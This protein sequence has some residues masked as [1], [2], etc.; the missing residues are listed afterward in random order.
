MKAL[1]IPFSASSLSIKRCLRVA[2]AWQA[3]GHQAIF[4]AG[5]EA[6]PALQ[7]AG[8]TPH[9]LPEVTRAQ[10]ER[11]L[12]ILW[13][14]PAYFQRNLR[15]EQ[16]LIAEL[17][18]DVVVSDYRLTSPAAARLAGLP[19]VSLQHTSAVLLGNRPDQ[20][21]RYLVFG[22][23][24]T[25]AERP[26]W[27]RRLLASL[28]QGLFSLPMLPLRYFL[29]RLGFRPAFSPLGL[30]SGDRVLV[31]DL[32]SLL[33]GELPPNCYVVGPLTLQLREPM[34]AEHSAPGE[35]PTITLVYSASLRPLW[36]QL[37]Q[38]LQGLAGQV[39]VTCSESPPP[40]SLRQP[41][42]AVQLPA[43]EIAPESRLVIHAGEPAVLLQ[44]LAWGAPSLLLPGSPEQMLTAVQVQ[45][46]HLGRSLWQPGQL[47]LPRW[48]S[49]TLPPGRLRQMIEALLSDSTFQQACQE[50]RRDIERLNP[51][52]AA[53][54]EIERFVKFRRYV[55]TQL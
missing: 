42:G 39:A 7:A 44:A 21:V 31:E 30:M 11:R 55:T 20:A 41:E 17:R 27:Q 14:T 35:V 26:S 51:P 37:C 50:R 6:Q 15:R 46:N 53:A 5:E 40:A 54:L 52:A 49:W 23:A 29:R 19:C 47:P 13:A 24:L 32:L 22:A 9:L 12:G 36:S 33:P 45:A 48:L 25:A 8:F 2:E 1:F 16:Q 28:F 38:A 34:P 10:F 43:G 3:R 18:P 4:A